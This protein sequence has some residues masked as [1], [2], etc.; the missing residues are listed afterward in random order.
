M[1]KAPKETAPAKSEETRRRILEAAIAKFQEHG[2][3]K[4]TM[5][6]IAAESGVATGLAYYYFRSKE[7]LVLAFYGKSNDE[8]RPLTAV[9][10][11]GKRKLEDRLA[12]VIGVKFEYYAEHRAFLGA[13]LG[14]AAD[15]ASRLSPFGE[16]S[17]PIRETEYGYFS[18]AL[19]GSDLKAPQDLKPFLPSLLWLF[20]MG[21]ILFWISDR[22]TAQTRTRALVEKSIPIVTGL[23][24]I[25]R[26]PLTRPLRRKVTDLLA[27]IYGESVPEASRVGTS[28]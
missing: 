3:E 23:L 1:A 24:R 2:F 12:A 15:P 7:D 20:Q 25:A 6:E 10:L 19:E 11:E 26:N 17:A 18:E 13:L 14:H 27:T 4:A 28:A 16:E 9:A 8:M 22:S 21:L 5:R